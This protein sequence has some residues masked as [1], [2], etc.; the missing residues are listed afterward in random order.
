MCISR[1]FSFRWKLSALPRV[2][3]FLRS[4][5]E[6]LKTSL[7]SC[8]A[9]TIKFVPLHRTRICGIEQ[10][11]VKIAFRAGVVISLVSLGHHAV[12]GIL[13][14][15]GNHF[16][17]HISSICSA[18]TDASCVFR[19]AGNFHHFNR[20]TFAAAVRCCARNS[21]NYEGSNR[22][23]QRQTEKPPRHFLQT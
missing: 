9:H 17:T 6:Y 11:L 16:R 15:P 14:V 4:E 21:R 5:E 13:H 10:H 18:I 19:L 2:A 20:F 23:Y 3:L 7:L 8:A 12:A 1:F 22:A